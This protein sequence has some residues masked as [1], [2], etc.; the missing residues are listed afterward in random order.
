MASAVARKNIV[1]AKS[2]AKRGANLFYRNRHIIVNRSEIW[3]EAWN[4]ENNSA[5]LARQ[6]KRAST[7]PGAM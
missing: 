1:R 5:I 2:D 3:N 7:S 6:G 4:A